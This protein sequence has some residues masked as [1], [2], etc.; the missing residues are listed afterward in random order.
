VKR[1]KADW[2]GHNVRGNCLLKDVNEGKLEGRIESDKK[3]RK[4]K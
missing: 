2:T 3:T 1:K 4:E